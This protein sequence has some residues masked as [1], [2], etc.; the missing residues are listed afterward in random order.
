MKEEAI[1]TKEY[2]KIFDKE[3]ENEIIEILNKD[4]DYYRF[5][6]MHYN[7]KTMNKI[8]ASRYYSTNIYSSTYNKDYLDFNRKEFLTNRDD[9]NYFLIPSNKDP[10]YN[11]FMGVKYIYSEEELT[12]PYKKM[13]DNVYENTTALPLIYA[14]NNTINIEEFNTYSYPYKN[15]ILLNSVVVD[16]SSNYKD[17]KIEK[18]NTNYNIISNNGVIISDNTLKVNK[19]G[20]LVVELEK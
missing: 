7:L 3:V 14:S 13:S 12:Y 2:N 16:G 4:T 17:V 9:Y 15:Y 20:K 5:A 18:L 1:S 11:S 6:N 10:L 8:Y 19:K